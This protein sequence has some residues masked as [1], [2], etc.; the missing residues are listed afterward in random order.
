MSLKIGQTVI[1]P[2]HGAAIIEEIK[3]LKI[4]GK[5]RKYV[6][7]RVTAGDLTIQVPA[8]NI[9]LVGVRSVVDED[10]LQEVLDVL[11][12]SDT[13]EPDNWSRRFKVNGEKIA[14]GDILKVS[15]VVRDLTARDKDRGLS[16]GEKRMLSKAR[17]ILVSELA[18]AKDEDEATAGRRLDQIMGESSEDKNPV[19]SSEDDISDT[20]QN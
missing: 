12:D 2:H 4:K 7:L 10:G 14:T 6:T 11:Q 18:L 13:K 15:E 20:A 3:T 8:E 16:T 9:D 5:E 19:P 1:Y 17:D